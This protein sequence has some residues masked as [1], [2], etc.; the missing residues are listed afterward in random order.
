MFNMDKAK[1][2]GPVTRPPILDGI[3]YDYWKLHMVVF[4]KSTDNKTWKSVIKGLIPP[5]III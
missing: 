5:N 4:L 1:E 2:G 3:N